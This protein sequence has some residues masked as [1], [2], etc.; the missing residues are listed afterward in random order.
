MCMFVVVSSIAE[1]QKNCIEYSVF[2]ELTNSMLDVDSFV[3]KETFAL[4]KGHSCESFTTL[5]I[6]L[7][8]RV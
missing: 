6:V 5:V 4:L 1:F 2:C 8:F 7:K 3:N